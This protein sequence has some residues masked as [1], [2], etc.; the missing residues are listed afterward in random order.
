MNS[1]KTLEAMSLD[2]LQ[3]GCSLSSPRYQEAM[4]WAQAFL[5]GTEHWSAEDR[6]ARLCQGVTRILE[7]D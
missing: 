3:A 1:A 7:D 6:W 2:L 4:R 5:D